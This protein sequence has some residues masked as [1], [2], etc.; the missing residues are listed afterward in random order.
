MHKWR[1]KNMFSHCDTWI[2]QKFQ[3]NKV[4]GPSQKEALFQSSPCLF[5]TLQI[6]TKYI[7][8]TSNRKERYNVGSLYTNLAW[9]FPNPY[10]TKIL[11][12]KY[13]TRLMFSQKYIKKKT[14]LFASRLKNKNKQIMNRHFN[15]QD[16]CRIIFYDKHKNRNFESSYKLFITVINKSNAM[17]KRK[18]KKIIT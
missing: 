2:Q 10:N 5:L 8:V 18:N 17:E 15:R 9:N 12:N 11:V 13:T 4:S 14:W 7:Q 6:F 16:I 1:R 3:E